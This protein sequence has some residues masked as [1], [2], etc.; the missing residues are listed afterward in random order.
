MTPSLVL[1]VV[2]F[3]LSAVILFPTNLIS[4]KSKYFLLGATVATFFLVGTLQLNA[5]FA[6]S[7]LAIFMF[8]ASSQQYSLWLRWGC[9]IFA[10]IEI[11]AIT[12]G[13]LPGFI[14]V[15]VVD[16]LLLGMSTIPFTLKIS[17][18]KGM[19][20][21]FIF[22]FWFQADTNFSDI[23]TK[24]VSSLLPACVLVLLFLLLAVTVGY[25][26]DPKWYWFTPWFLIGNTCL[27]VIAEEVFFRGVMQRKLLEVLMPY[28]KYAGVIALILVAVFFAALHLKG[29]LV[30]AALT[31]VAGLIYGWIYWRYQSIYSAILCHFSVNMLHFIF[32]KYPG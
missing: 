16:N 21:L 19:V 15:I 27:T 7:A 8:V 11:F 20:G 22:V 3:I 18:A 6:F 14:S 17:Y 24:L 25:H 23:K 9:G 12:L 5:V 26:L 32:L 31:F 2:F 13:R 10:T 28:T 29:G 4:I 1:L 30:Y